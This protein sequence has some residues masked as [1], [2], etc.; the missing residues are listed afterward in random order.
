MFKII[1]R[2]Q[3]SDATLFY[4]DI[5]KKG[6]QKAGGKADDAYLSEDI[7]GNDVVTLNPPQ[8]VRMKLK[9]AKSVSV[10][11]QGIDAEEY[12]RFVPVSKFKKV[13]RYIVLSIYDWIALKTAKICFFVSKRMLEYYRKKYGYKKNNYVIMPCF[14]DQIKGDAF[15]DS[16]YKK[17]SF[18][19][20]GNLAGWQCFPK[21]V[22]L[23][24]I[25]KDKLPTA[26]LTVYTPD[27]EEAKAILKNNGVTASVKYVPYTQLAEE[28]KGFKYGFLIRDDDPVN[29]VATPT[30]MCNYL[31]NGIIPLYTNVIGDFKEELRCL[32][33]SVPVDTRFGGIE[34]LFELEKSTIRAD[35]VKKDFQKVF[36][37]Y[38]SEEYYVELIASKIKEFYI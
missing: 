38:Y 11:F 17:P 20:A 37:R 16:K 18:V 26:T 25:I 33:Y 28:I 9:G 24:K 3:N 30:K 23:F 34:K 14:N 32:K 27:Q 1:K 12:L 6:I 8:L 2:Q 15:V 21:I 5:I 13:E 22:E 19:Y 31:A 4:M 35:E 10:W 29:N 36:D 7:K